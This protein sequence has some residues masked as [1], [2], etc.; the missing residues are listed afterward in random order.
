MNLK[1]LGFLIK[2]AVSEGADKVMADSAALP[3]TL[4]KA[5]AFRQFG[6]INVQRW[7]QEGLIHAVRMD[8]M[9]S[10]KRFD[11]FKLEAVARVSNRTTDLPVAER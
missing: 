9:G 5:Q 6:Q 10:K 2:D 8:G 4:T 7:L 11:R 3:E 1:A